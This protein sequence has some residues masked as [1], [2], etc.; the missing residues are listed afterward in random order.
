[1]ESEMK[2]KNKEIEYGYKSISLEKSGHDN[3]DERSFVAVITDTSVDRSLEVMLPDGGNFKDF[4]LNPVVLFN[5]NH[6]EQVGIAE[7]PRKRGDSVVAKAIIA[8]EG[9]SDT[10]DKVWKLIKQGMLKGVSVGFQILERR[11]ANELDK[12]MFGKTVE[13]VIS[14]WKLLEFS[15][16]TIPC[17]QNALITG[18][19]SLDYNDVLEDVVEEDVDD[20][21]IEDEKAEVKDIEEMRAIIE[22]EIDEEIKNL[23]T[24]IIFAEEEKK[25]L[26]QVVE[27][28]RVDIKEVIKYMKIGIKEAL[29]KE[30]GQMFDD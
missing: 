21:G 23:E 25:R 13:R 8:E 19:K 28:K 20:K 3:E 12:K 24:D 14:K 16:V 2:N 11:N 1:M 6:D 17:N 15:V 10:V 7:K 5:H 4:N 27:E 26:V 22:T 29:A 30:K 18:F 9:T